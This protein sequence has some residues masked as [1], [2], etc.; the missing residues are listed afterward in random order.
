MVALEVEVSY[1]S[2]VTVCILDNHICCVWCVHSVFHY[3]SLLLVCVGLGGLGGG[4]GGGL[5]GG[6]GGMAQLGLG[7]GGGGGLGGASSGLGL[8]LGGSTLGRGNQ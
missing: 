2:M 1:V 7:G 5:S 6:L 8:G 4:L 3:I